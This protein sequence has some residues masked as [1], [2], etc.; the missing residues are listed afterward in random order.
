MP[1]IQEPVEQ[2][3][4][5]GE[6]LNFTALE[7]ELN[8]LNLRAR[9][10]MRGYVENSIIRISEREGLTQARLDKI[11]EEVHRMNQV[12]EEKKRKKL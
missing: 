3:R 2:A 9:E 5:K 7:T 12:M 8:G 4:L 10:Q 11:E 6:V 1:G